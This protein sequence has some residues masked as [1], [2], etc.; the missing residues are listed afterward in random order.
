MAAATEAVHQLGTRES[1]LPAAARMP[2]QQLRTVEWCTT[3]EEAFLEP[4]RRHL[5]RN[6]PRTTRS[7]PALPPV[8]PP[9]SACRRL[10]RSPLR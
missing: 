7:E 9:C 10:P 3:E 1:Y 4:W 5:P 8:Q 6:D 2:P